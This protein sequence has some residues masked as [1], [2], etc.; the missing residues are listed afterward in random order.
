[1]EPTSYLPHRI[2]VLAILEAGLLVTIAKFLEFLFFEL[3]PINGLTGNNA[4]Y[5][6]MECMPQ[7]M[8]STRCFINAS[9][10]AN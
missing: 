1:M 6:M 8:V 2:V 3:A 10:S 4:L 7:L 9:P 5:V